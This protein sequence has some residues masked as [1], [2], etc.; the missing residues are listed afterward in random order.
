MMP[1]VLFDIEFRL[2]PSPQ[3]CEL[4]HVFLPPCEILVLCRNPAFRIVVSEEYNT[5]D[6]PESFTRSH[7][8]MEAV[9]V[10]DGSAYIP[11]AGH[12]WMMDNETHEWTQYRH[13]ISNGQYFKQGIVIDGNAYLLSNTYL[14]RLS[15]TEE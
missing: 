14:Y 9:V 10:I 5:Y 1:F 12:L 3:L 8:G 13:A 15:I 2:E 4:M 7:S 6:F 11:F